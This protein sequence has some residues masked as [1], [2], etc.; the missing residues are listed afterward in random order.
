MWSSRPAICPLAA[1]MT[2]LLW[3]TL[4]PSVLRISG[5]P[6]LSLTLTPDPGGEVPGSA[7]VRRER[8]EAGRSRPKLGSSVQHRGRPAVPPGRRT[9]R[10]AVPVAPYG[11]QVLLARLCVV[12]TLVLGALVLG[13]LVVVT[14][15][16]VTFM[17]VTLMVGTLVIAERLATDAELVKVDL[18]AGRV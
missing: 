13:A 1:A 4:S 10:P 12:V 14:L 7:G 15:M 5:L 18:L 9:A 6:A 2:S 3:L 8:Q 17:V 16:V 11:Y